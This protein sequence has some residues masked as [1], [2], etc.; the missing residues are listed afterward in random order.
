MVRIN[1]SDLTVY[2]DISKTVCVR[3][4]MRTE[5]ANDLY[6]RG[7]GIA[8]HALALKIYNGKGEQEFTDEEYDLL[9]AYVNQVGTP[10]MIDVLSDLKK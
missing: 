2:T 10:M 7:Q 4:D 9:M 1:F 5:L 6:T 8:F 3:Q